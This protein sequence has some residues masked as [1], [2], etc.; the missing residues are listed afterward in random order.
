MLAMSPIKV[1]AKPNSIATTFTARYAAITCGDGGRETLGDGGGGASFSLV[2]A[3]GGRLSLSGRQRGANAIRTGACS[4]PGMLIRLG[5]RGPH[6]RERRRREP[7][8]FARSA[9]KCG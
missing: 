4:C 8:Y 6:H 3:M 1:A 5:G 2:L 9:R 7:A